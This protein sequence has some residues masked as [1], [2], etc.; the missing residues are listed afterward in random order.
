MAAD[1]GMVL[2]WHRAM[3]LEVAC[4]NSVS[5]TVFIGSMRTRLE[6]TIYLW[7]G[8]VDRCRVAWSSLQ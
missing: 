3:P 8:L 4:V 6:Q 5:L 1:G 7:Q 2:T